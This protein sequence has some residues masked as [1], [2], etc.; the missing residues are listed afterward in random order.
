MKRE[1]GLILVL[2]VGAVACNKPQGDGIASEA[3]AGR[4]SVVAP[5][6]TSAA[7]KP[8]PAT[9]VTVSPGGGTTVTTTGGGTKVKTSD[10]TNVDTTGGGT[11]VK[12][13]DGTNVDTTKGVQVKTGGVNVVVPGVNTP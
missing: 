2:L 12:T 13:P 9:A 5:G 6:A 3:D 8:G 11:K 1:L 10:G 7:T 4:S